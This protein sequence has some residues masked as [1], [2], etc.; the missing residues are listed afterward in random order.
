MDNSETLVTL[1]TQDTG[2]RQ[3]KHRQPKG[4]SRMDNPEKLSTMY[5]KRKTNTNTTQTTKGMNGH[6]QKQGMNTGSRE[7]ESVPAN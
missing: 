3:T 5:T 4:R 6:H 2:R 1:G 7:R